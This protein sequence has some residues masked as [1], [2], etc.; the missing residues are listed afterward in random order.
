MSQRFAQ[1]QPMHTTTVRF[2]ADFWA[3]LGRIALWLQLPKAEVI[4]SGTREHVVRL[5]SGEQVLD[6]VAGPRLL[7]VER[8]LDRVEA[9]VAGRRGAGA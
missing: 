4:R 1:Q 5:E 3:R 7:R 6:M 9:I 2:D 8:R